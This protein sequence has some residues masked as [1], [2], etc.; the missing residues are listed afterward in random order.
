MLLHASYGSPGLWPSY[1]AK[2]CPGL[3]STT[4]QDIIRYF[5]PWNL[6]DFVQNSTIALI[7]TVISL[8]GIAASRGCYYLH[9]RDSLS[10]LVHSTEILYLANCDRTRQRWSLVPCMALLR[11]LTCTVNFPSLLCSL[12]WRFLQVNCAIFLLVTQ[13]IR[14]I[15]H[16]ESARTVTDGCG[17][18]SCPSP[19][20]AAWLSRPTVTARVPGLTVPAESVFSFIIKLNVHVQQGLEEIYVILA[21][22][23]K[24]HLES[25]KDN[26][27]HPFWQRDSQKR[28]NAPEFI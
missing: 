9:R 26:R 13:H 22:E 3:S 12:Q 17:A 24:R 1:G 5:I 2:A 4:S 10:P 18:V 28:I 8:I 16:S 27:L 23:I 6:K 19:V 20:T 21:G 14:R 15:R 7:G 25:G 11:F